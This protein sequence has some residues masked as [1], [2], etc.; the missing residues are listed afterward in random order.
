MMIS[1]KKAGSWASLLKKL[2]RIVYLQ[3]VFK[4]CK[5]PVL[6]SNVQYIESTYVQDPYLRARSRDLAHGN[7]RHH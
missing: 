7:L 5:I 2:T 1:V 6:Y 4:V 3:V